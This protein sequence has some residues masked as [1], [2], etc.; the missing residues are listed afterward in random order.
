MQENYIRINKLKVSQKLSKFVSDELLK[1]TNI[2]VED[3][4][5][6]FEKALDEL[7]PK[8]KELIKLREDLQKKIDDWHIKNKDSDFDFTEY[9]KF[10]LEI[11]YLKT[12]GANFKIWPF[13]FQVTNF[14]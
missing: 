11:G 5:L 3:F 2:S 9:K 12:E 13:L 14:F 10:L 4:W 6:G 1:D 8:N 7:S